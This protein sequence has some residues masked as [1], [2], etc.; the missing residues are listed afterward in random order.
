MDEFTVTVYFK[1][2]EA[3]TRSRLQGADRVQNS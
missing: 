2:L 1:L 3:S